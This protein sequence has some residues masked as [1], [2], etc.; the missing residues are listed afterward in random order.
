M[1]DKDLQD[2]PNPEET[3]QEETMTAEEALNAGRIAQDED[4]FEEA[5]EAYEYAIERAEETDDDQTIA[6]ALFNIGSIQFMHK[7]PDSALD[8]FQEAFT[9]YERAGSQEGM[10]DSL[11]A[12]SEAWIAQGNLQEATACLHKVLPLQAADAFAAGRG[13]TWKRLAALSH[14]R[15]DNTAAEKEYRQALLAFE[16]AGSAYEIADCH[17]KIGFIYKWMGD[18]VRALEAFETALPFAQQSG[19]EFLFHSVEDSI[20]EAKEKLNIAGAKTAAKSTEK[21]GLFGR[22]FG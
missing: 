22:L 10:V 7:F 12:Q 2:L 4:R 3:G 17:S 5:V 16:T 6:T 11:H 1:E 13:Y 21:K 9:H 15:G 19:D 18:W 14:H 20:E 8:N